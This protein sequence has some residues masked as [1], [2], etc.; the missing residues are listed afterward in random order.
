[1]GL[2]TTWGAET[3]SQVLVNALVLESALLNS[4]A[5]RVISDSRVTHVPRLKV[6]PQAAWTAELSPLPSDSGDSDILILTPRK[7]GTTLQL[8]TEAIQDSSVDALDA[9]GNAMVR[10]IAKT[11][12]AAAFSAN[13]A[14]ATVPAGLLSY[15]LPGSG[16][17]GIVD[18]D[19][20]LSGVGAI[21]GVG[22]SPDTCFCN[23]A[24]ITKIRQQKATTGQYIVA[25]DAADV[26]GQP[27]V[28]IAGCRLLPSAGMV[29]GKAL[30]CQASFIQTCIRRDASVDFSGDAAFTS[31]AVV[32]RVTMRIDWNIGDPNALWLISP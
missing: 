30:V 13:A 27:T 5:T 29:A 19:H 16:T 3:W 21:Q 6:Y 12:D 31:D 15:T 7:L 14:T 9:V 28:R 24:D 8:S 2:S 32:A 11:L 18:I 26:E 25:P 1:M 23:P 4:G 17:G 20:I 10:G 22:G